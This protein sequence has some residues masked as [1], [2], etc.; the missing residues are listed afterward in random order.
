VSRSAAREIKDSIS[1]DT[2]EADVNDAYGG[3]QAR[4]GVETAEG[5]D[6]TQRLPPSFTPR[7]G[8]PLM[9]MTPW[10]PIPWMPPM[11]HRSAVP[12][13]S[14]GWRSSRKPM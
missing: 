3:A 11:N 13:L 6:P 4:D 2:L 10:V 1:C 7:P 5:L 8:P 12:W 14:S 9:R